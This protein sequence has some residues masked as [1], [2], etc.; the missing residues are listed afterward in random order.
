M[1]L[2]GLVLEWHDTE[3]DLARLQHSVGGPRFPREASL[4]NVQQQQAA[5]D[6]TVLAELEALRNIQMTLESEKIA[7][8][9]E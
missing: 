8:E 4:D 7:L 1:R 9:S 5:I 2:E 3:F 6:P